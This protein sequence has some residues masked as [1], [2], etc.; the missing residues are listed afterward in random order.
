MLALSNIRRISLVN[1]FLASLSATTVVTITMLMS[2]TD[3]VRVLG[4][5]LLGA[6]TSVTARYLVGGVVHL[7][8]GITYGVLFALFFA[9]VSE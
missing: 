5:M 3:I 1:V 2:G 8:V 6:D 7:S 9:P 4:G